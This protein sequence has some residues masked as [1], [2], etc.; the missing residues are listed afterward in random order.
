[1]SCHV[2]G[3]SRAIAAQ[4]VVYMLT[5]AV[6]GGAFFKYIASI[7]ESP[8]MLRWLAGSSGNSSSAGGNGGGGGSSAGSD[9]IGK[10]LRIESHQVTVE[11][12]IAEGILCEF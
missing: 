9:Y 10:V 7:S 8:T 3:Y 12:V 6:A 4:P 11:E 2:T 5:S 1:M